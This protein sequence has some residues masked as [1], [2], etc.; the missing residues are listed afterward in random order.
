MLEY[1]AQL[2]PICFLLE[3]VSVAGYSTL[4]EIQKLV[5]LSINDISIICTF[6]ET[7]NEVEYTKE[8]W[9]SLVTDWENNNIL[10]DVMDE[11]Q[12]AVEKANSYIVY[13]INELEDIY[14]DLCVTDSLHIT[15]ILSTINLR[16]RRLLSQMR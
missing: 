9:Q 6:N 1:F 2:E 14:K 13:P 15:L 11:D 4:W 7:E 16:W 10:I 8:L 5:E 12:K 3:N